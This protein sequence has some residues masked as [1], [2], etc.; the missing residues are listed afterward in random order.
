MDDKRMCDGKS[1]NDSPTN[2]TP[3][4]E[5]SFRRLFLEWLDQNQ[6]ALESGGAGDV[7]ALMTLLSSWGVQASPH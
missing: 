1:A 5:A 2:I 6:D 4:Q 7:R 3:T